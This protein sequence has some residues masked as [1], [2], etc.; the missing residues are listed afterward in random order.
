MLSNFD[1]INIKELSE[2]Y[3]SENKDTFITLFLNIESYD[4]K[5]LE[6]RKKSCISVLKGNKDLLTNFNRTVKMIERYLK[7]MAREKDLKGLALFASHKNN[8]FRAYKL[9]IPLE[10]MMVVDTSPY[11]RP[12]VRLIDEYE[13]FGLVLLDS[14]RAEIYVV[15]SGKIE[16]EGERVSDIMNKHKKGGWSQ[17]RFQRLREGAIDHFLKGVVEDVEKISSDEE[18]KRIVIA[19]SGNAKKTFVDMI[20]AGIKSNVIDVI[21]VEFDQAEGRL[22]SKAEKIVFEDEKKRS[23]GNIEKLREEILKDGLGVH[24]LKETLDAVENGQ[25]DTL[26]VRKG[27][28]VRGWICEK[29]QSVGQGHVKIC[30]NCES[31]TSEADMIEEIIEFA[32]RKETVI[33][34]VEGNQ[35]LEKLGGIGG[36]L[37]YR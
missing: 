18:I 4:D 25:V 9:R 34:F 21:D 8:F 31:E 17:A 1:D 37:R 33:D 20:P 36:L 32:E 23:D 6:K 3:D 12:L 30:P 10:D 35:M 19:G 7:K 22:I 11:V 29:C 15:S 14:H 13:S 26:L 16:V 27:L 2:I 28:K 5:F 24:G